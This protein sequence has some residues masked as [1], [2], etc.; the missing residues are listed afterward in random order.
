MK[1]VILVEVEEKKLV[2]IWLVYNSETLPKDL[3]QNSL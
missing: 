1:Y 3:F 2:K